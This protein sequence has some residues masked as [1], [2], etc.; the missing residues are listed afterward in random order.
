MTQVYLTGFSFASVTFTVPRRTESDFRKMLASS[1]SE[2][3]VSLDLDEVIF[4]PADD[5]YLEKPLCFPLNRIYRER[6][7]LGIPA[8]FHMLNSDNY[9]IW[10]YTAEYYSI[11]YIR[12]YFHYYTVKIDGIVTGTGRKRKGFA[13]ERI[14]LEELVRERYKQTLHIDRQTVLRTFSGSKDFEEYPVVEGA[15]G[16]AQTVKSIIRK[17]EN[18]ESYK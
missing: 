13:E 3:R 1:A 14:S 16:W 15:F 11:E 2:R 8:L 10:V 18:N 4:R 17:F 12:E 9:D 7:R 6:L 5:P